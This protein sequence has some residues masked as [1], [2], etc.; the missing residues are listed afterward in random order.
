MLGSK[1]IKEKKIPTVDE[2]AKDYMTIKKKPYN[3]INLSG[4]NITEK[5]IRQNMAI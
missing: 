1:S 3:R 2:M 5:K 4:C